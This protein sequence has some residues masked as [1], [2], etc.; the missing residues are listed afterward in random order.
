MPRLPLRSAVLTAFVVLAT[1]CTSMLPVRATTVESVD[2]P[3]YMGL[4][5]EVASVKQFFS[6]G[7]VGTTA[8]YTLRDDGVVEVVNQGRYFSPQGPLSIIRGTAVA[9][10][11]SGARLNVS[12]TGTNPGTPPGNYWIV[13]LDPDYQWA[14]V[15]D[16]SGTSCFILSR[17]P[18][19]SAELRAQLL[20]RAAAAGVDVSNVTDTPQP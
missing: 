18:T 10:D 20:E 16:P 17:T 1:A 12:F 5:Y 2:I 15:S 13:A 19:I 9:V 6:I 14:V 4:W 8:T 11:P 3:R 7:L